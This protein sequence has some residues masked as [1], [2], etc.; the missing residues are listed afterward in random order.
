LPIDKVSEILH[1]QESRGQTRRDLLAVSWRVICLAQVLAL[2]AGGCVLDWRE[3]RPGCKR[4]QS[5]DGGPVDTVKP[6]MPPPDAPVPDMP[7]PDLPV[8]DLPVP[9]LPAPDLPVPDLPI[10]D[11]PLPDAPAP[12]MAPVQ[13]LTDDYH[14]DFTKGAL[15]QAGVKIYVART[16]KD[17]KTGKYQGSVQLVD[18]LDLNQDGYLDLPLASQGLAASSHKANSII[19]WGT[20][21]WPNPSKP[22]PTLIPS[23]NAR[24]VATAD[25]D[26]DGYPDLFLVNRANG[27]DSHVMHG[28]GKGTF[29]P[30]SPLE[31]RHGTSVSVADLDGDGYLDLVVG[32]E[33]F[34]V[35]KPVSSRVFWGTPTGHSTANVDELSTIGA[36][37]STVADLDGDK[38]L[39][40]VFANA[41]DSNSH[42]YR[43]LGGKKFAASPVKLPTLGARGA[44]VAD[45]DGDKHLDIVFANSSDG[46]THKVDSYIYWGGANGKYS[47]AA[48]T[49]LPTLGA[50]GVS[51]ADL[52]GDTHLDLVF[53]NRGDGTPTAAVNSYIY[54]GVALGKF[55]AAN[56][57]ELATVRST[58]N[59]V[60]DFNGDSYPDIAFA[61]GGDT[62]IFYG[63]STRKT[64]YSTTTKLAT[65]SPG[66]VASSDPGA[67]VDR[68]T[69][70]LFTS[71][72]LATTAASPKYLTLSWTAKVPLKTAL[73]LRVRSAATKTALD[74]AAW[75]AYLSKS[76][77]S[78]SAQ[79]GQH[80]QYQAE[81]SSADHGSSP[82][83]EKVVISYQ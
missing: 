50:S 31:T 41:A 77:A 51:V 35:L 1:D 63:E 55:T 9:D 62:I 83:L 29:A 12:D 39:D 43:G 57:R 70:Y 48:R 42:I 64:S 56:K 60:A 14:E 34:L 67:V 36:A 11:L 18:H 33:E 54:W 30:P 61:G 52:D 46:K 73:R 65:T 76:G 71:R 28:K 20:S 27:K 32:N 4:D 80:I 10:P 78:I 21:S 58:G 2:A 69:S 82:V 13:K 37:D 5:M 6:D 49:G 38:H 24:G 15:I 8:P 16:A 25:L 79:K 45:L 66:H 53:S 23:T 59:L 44:A 26:A 72:K 68:K 7:T 40:I 81:L 74:T 22:S 17:V 19:Y 47:T 75:S 3:D